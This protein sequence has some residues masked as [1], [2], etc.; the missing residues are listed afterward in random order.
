MYV[1][2][3]LSSVCFRVR[4]TALHC[5]EATF[6]MW[7][8][9]LEQTVVVMHWRRWQRALLFPNYSLLLRNC[10]ADWIFNLNTSFI[11]FP[12]A[13]LCG[14]P[15]LQMRQ[16][17]PQTH[18]DLSLFRATQQRMTLP[19]WP[20]SRFCSFSR[21]L[22]SLFLAALVASFPIQNCTRLIKKIR[23]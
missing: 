17:P 19:V 23:I 15:G 5:V 22:M 18:T 9:W 20:T 8:T 6:V 2:L 14:T 3:L 13:P 7:R 4:F 10:I 12:S 21:S 11:Q 1:F 16:P